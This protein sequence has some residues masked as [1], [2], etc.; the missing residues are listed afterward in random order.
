MKKN[1]KHSRRDFLKLAGLGFFGSL[2]ALSSFSIG[3]SSKNER[4]NKRPNILL[5]MVDDMG[6]SDPSCYGGEIYTPNISKLAAAGLRFTQ[7]H[8]CARCCPT[9]ASLMTG[10]YAHQV[11]LRE[12]GQ[13]L[14]RDGITIAE[15]LKNAGYH[16]AMVGKWHLSKTL[17]HPVRK[18]HQKWVDHQVEHEPFAPLETY[19]VNRGFDKFYGVI[20]GVI[21]HFDPFSLVEGEKPVKNVPEGYYFTDAITDRAIEYIK[22]FVK[23]DEP[24]FLYYSHCAPHW[25]LHAR[26]EDIEK[27]KETYLGGWAKLRQDRY[28]RQLEM[29]L[30]DEHTAKLP[31]LM[32]RGKT[33]K[34]LSDERKLYEAR[35][36]AVHGAMIDRI[37]QNLGRVLET[38]EQTG[39]YDN[40][41][42]IF[43]SDN[44]ASPEKVEW[45]PGY[46]RTAQTREGQKLMYEY[47]NPAP[48]LIGSE[49]TYLAIG[50]AW[51]NA[52]NTPFKYWK[53]QSYEG[54]MNTPCIIHWPKGLNAK[55]GSITAE[56]AHVMDIMPTCLELAGA[57]YPKQYKGHVIL[58]LEGSS[59]VGLIKGEKSKRQEEYYF[60][61][62]KG[63]AVRKAGWKLV[64]HTDSPEKWELY[65]IAEDL[66]ETRDLA[67]QYPEKVEEMQNAW[68]AWSVRV[69]LDAF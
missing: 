11:G 23:S 64:A 6:F 30:F 69:G 36:M 8:N 57:T 67:A 45:G 55:P 58:P 5:I 13:S 29:G 38:L 47:D 42:I 44:G 54:G 2:P 18:K 25:P 15:G 37:D 41:V 16:T 33:W 39:Q 27:Y 34:S 9:R 53:M 63:R 14:T 28:A 19:P 31:A 12:N 40:T 50:P 1:D 60:E 52:T 32:D 46:D 20:W 56:P 66:T 49:K 22:G 61:H 48:D 68:Q 10:L 51:A 21:N 4:S 26:K 62:A 65:H 43:L 3:N 59:L 17:W 7:F 24:F 35:Q